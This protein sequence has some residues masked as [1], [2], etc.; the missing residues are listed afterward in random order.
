MILHIKMYGHSI[1]DS[2]GSYIYLQQ[3]L[4]CVMN[5]AYINT[6]TYNQQPQEM[7]MPRC[8]TDINSF[9]AMQLVA[10]GLLEQL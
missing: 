6:T 8:H 5:T 7:K 2:A 4:W 9:S 10:N 1:L 3:C